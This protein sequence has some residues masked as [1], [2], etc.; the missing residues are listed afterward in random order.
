METSSE[1]PDIVFST[2]K[3]PET[4]EMKLHCRKMEV[5]N[6]N[7]F[8]EDFD[9]CWD[10]INDSVLS[11]EEILGRFRVF[12]EGQIESL[13]GTVENEKIDA[14]KTVLNLEFEKLSGLFGFLKSSI[15]ENQWEH[16]SQ[17]EL[18]TIVFKS[19]FETL[20][21]EFQLKLQEQM[22]ALRCVQEDWGNKVRDFNTL[23]EELNSISQSLLLETE[24]D[25]N[26]N[27]SKVN[28]DFH[29]ED[30]LEVHLKH[31]SKGETINYFKSEITKMRRQNEIILAEKTEELF[32]LKREFLKEKGSVRKDKDFEFIRAKL[33]EIIAKMDE[34]LRNEVKLPLFSVGQREEICRLEAKINFL[35]GENKNLRDLVEKTKNEVKKFD[36]S[37]EE[38]LNKIE[39]LSAKTENL[40]ILGDA[41]DMINRTVLEEAFERHMCKIEKLSAE[42]ENL[43]ILGDVKDMINRTV[44]EE[45]FEGHMCKIEDMRIQMENL[46]EKC[47]VQKK[48]VIGVDKEIEKFTEIIS[49]LM[50]GN[51]KLVLETSRLE[52]QRNK[53]ELIRVETERLKEKSR[54]QKGY[55]LD[56][57]REREVNK[58]KLDDALKQGMFDKITEFEN[59]FQESIERNENRLRK[60]S[61]ELSTL[62]QSVNQL[63]KNEMRYRQMLQIRTSNLEKA[64]AEVDLL[65]DEVDALLS[66][67]GH[68]YIALDHYS[69]VFVHY[70]GVTEILRLVKSELQGKHI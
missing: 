60:L 43:K 51:E 29:M 26:P 57:K 21:D 16:K 13:K 55:I 66:L 8:V 64:E 7:Y 59:V 41:K 58:H 61:S 28:K 50:D 45:V 10:E 46:Q 35:L 19:Y 48:A 17:K 5:C 52:K 68:I 1:K 22:D 63:K 49:F 3:I 47:F 36:S 6:E 69:P 31:L 56:L 9:L 27:I 20:H 18:C 62:V 44:L 4:T 30:E 14:V 11:F 34:M 42:I 67:L 39:K 38:Y 37:M 24:V 15:L 25:K 32:K 53:I 70:P 33:P 40:K 54:N 65:G 2:P 12:M 23:R